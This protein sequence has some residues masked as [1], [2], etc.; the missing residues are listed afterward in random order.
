MLK[1]RTQVPDVLKIF[2]NEIKTQFPTSIRILCTD[3]AL[4]FLKHNV[5]QFY[6]SNGILHQTTCAHTSQQNGVAERKYQHLLDVARTLM[7]QMHVP[8]YL[9]ADA[10]DCLLFD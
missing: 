9:Q 1:D 4:E 2:Y 8:K 5:S 6:Y 3:N 7:I 10:I